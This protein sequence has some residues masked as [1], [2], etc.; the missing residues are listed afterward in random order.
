MISTVGTLTIALPHCL[1]VILSNLFSMR[2]YWV[3]PMMVIGLFMSVISMFAASFC[4][5]VGGLLV[6]QGIGFGTGA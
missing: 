1:P 6:T 4:T 3:K 5:S 2:P